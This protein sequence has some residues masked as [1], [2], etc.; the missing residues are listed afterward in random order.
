MATVVLAYT[1]R[2]WGPRA[3]RTVR[4]VRA[5]RAVARVRAAAVAEEDFS[6]T[7]PVEAARAIYAELGGDRPDRDEVAR[8]LGAGAGSWLYEH[9][10]LGEGHWAVGPPTIDLIRVLERDA[11]SP[12]RVVV[13]VRG[14][15]LA[16]PPS[17]LPDRL[18]TARDQAVAF[19]TMAR[20]D[21]GWSLAVVEPHGAGARHLRADP[22]ELRAR[23]AEALRDAATIESATADVT[24]AATELTVARRVVG[25]D[26]ARAALLDLSLVDGRFAPHV[27][28]RSVVRV[29]RAWEETGSGDAIGLSRLAAPVARRQ[30]ESASSIDRPWIDDFTPVEVDTRRRSPSVVVMATARGTAVGLRREICWRFALTDEDDVPWRLADAQ[31]WRDVYLWRS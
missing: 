21:D 19:W 31:A 26:E 18:V 5:K 9:S 8:L 17:W 28:E 25:A 7:A 23:E 13:C 30:L 3:V 14:P 12:R 29:L 24:S 2:L 16:R 4:Q 10:E 6:V 22:G 1:W 11:A 27:I 15:L 20:E